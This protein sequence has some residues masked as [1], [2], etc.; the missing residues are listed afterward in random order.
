MAVHKCGHA[1]EVAERVENKKVLLLRS[2]KEV[3]L[4]LLLPA[5]LPRG[6][7]GRCRRP[8]SKSE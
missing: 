1:A 7:T 5:L 8:S 6:R 3:L 4:P 2:S